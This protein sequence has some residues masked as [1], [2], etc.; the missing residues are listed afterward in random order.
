MQQASIITDPNLVISLHTYFP[1]NFGL[2]TT[3][4]AWG[5]VMDYTDMRASIEQQIRVWL[6]TQAIFIG[7]WGSMGAQ[8]MANRVAHA[9]AYAQDTTTAGLVP[10]WWD[11]GGSGSGSFSLFNRSTGTVSQPEIVNA[12]MTGV[13]NGLA[14]PNTWATHP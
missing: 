1:T 8:A 6:P 5:S 12:I 10:I 11:N 2:S 14:G 9:Q 13:R 3:P 7:E 4:Y